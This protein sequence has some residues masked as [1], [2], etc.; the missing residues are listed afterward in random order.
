MGVNR[1]AVGDDEA[2]GAQR[3]EAD[4]VRAARDA[5]LRCAR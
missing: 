1:A 3:L 2:F 4:I 5:R